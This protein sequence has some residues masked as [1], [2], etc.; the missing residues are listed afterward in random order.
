[1]VRLFIDKGKKDGLHLKLFLRELSRQTGVKENN[2]HNIQLSPQYSFVDVAA[3]TS[4]KIL[5]NKAIKLN[6]KPTKIELAT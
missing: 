3:D 6:S 2:F 1:M 5:K 4:K